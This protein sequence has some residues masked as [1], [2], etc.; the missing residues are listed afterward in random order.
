MVVFIQPK[1]IKYQTE[2]PDHSLVACYF[3]VIF[4]EQIKFGQR[5]TGMETTDA[6]DFDDGIGFE[7]YNHRL[8]EYPKDDEDADTSPAELE[9]DGVRPSSFVKNANEEYV[10]TNADTPPAE[11]D[12][13]SEV[14]ANATTDNECNPSLFSDSD[15]SHDSSYSRFLALNKKWE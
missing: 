9:K 1:C 14:G 8:S 13:A 12:Q 6:V 7:T 10:N 4:S 11:P 5:F 15:S 2:H 3:Y